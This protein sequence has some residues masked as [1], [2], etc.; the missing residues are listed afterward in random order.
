MRNS[1]M[2]KTLK[3]IPQFEQVHP[4]ETFLYSQKSGRDIISFVQQTD[5]H[6]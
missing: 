2:M 4:L 5:A 1:G 6:L 3:H